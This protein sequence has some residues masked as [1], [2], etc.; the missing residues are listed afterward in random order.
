VAITEPLDLLSGFPGWSTTF[1]LGWRQE[2]SRHASGRTRVKDFGSPL[3]QAQYQSRPLSR[4]QLSYWRARLDAAENGLVTFTAYDMSRCRPMAHQGSGTL[5]VG[6]LHTIDDNDK[7]VRVDN[8]T[9]ITLS[10]G[11]MIQI[12]TGLYRVQEA[13]T[14]ASGLT[15]LFE[16]RPH[17]WA[18]TAVGDEVVIERPSCL[19]T[20]VPGSIQASSDMSGRGAISWQAIEARG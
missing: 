13:A 11:D 5:P 3:W 10:V 19:M 20:V 12:G 17:L 9:G 7:A 18:G 16:V 1:E 14:A 4:R 8:L 2:Q 15:P 6:E